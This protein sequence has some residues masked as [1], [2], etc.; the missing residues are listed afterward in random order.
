MSLTTQT[1]QAVEALRNKLRREYGAFEV[2]EKTWTHSPSQYETV[3]ERA[4]NGGLGGAGVWLTNDAGEV[5]LVRNEGDDGWCDPGGKV[6]PGESYEVAARRETREEAGVECEL[7]G[8]REVHVIENRCSEADHPSVFEAIV[9]FDGVYTGGDP[10][11][12]PGEIAEVGWFE[13][14]PSSVLYDEVATRPYP[15]SK[16]DV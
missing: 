11:A 9:I 13:R 2:V 6:E 5:L 15:A 14:S 12:R 4:E 7:T 10:R 8:V 3:L 1:I 16:S